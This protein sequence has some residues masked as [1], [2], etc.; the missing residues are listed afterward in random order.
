MDNAAAEETDFYV[1][2]YS[3]SQGEAFG[4]FWDTVLYLPV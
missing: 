4:V 1:L 2:A 3:R